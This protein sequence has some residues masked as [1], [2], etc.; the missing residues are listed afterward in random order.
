[1]SVEL[2]NGTLATR[3]Q[4]RFG[5]LPDLPDARD[6]LFSA[7]EAVLTTLPSKVDLRR[8]MPSVYDLRP[9]PQAERRQSVALWA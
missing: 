4:Q 3:P 1:M 2:V 8:Q 7:P 6:Y 9:D 5:W